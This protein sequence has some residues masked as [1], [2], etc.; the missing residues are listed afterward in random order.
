[1][2]KAKVSDR[3][4]STSWSYDLSG[5]GELRQLRRSKK[6]RNSIDCE[7]NVIM[8][9]GGLESR[10]A[11]EKFLLFLRGCCAYT[12]LDVALNLHPFLLAGITGGQVA[13]LFVPLIISPSIIIQR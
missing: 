9:G 7:D 12:L 8:A 13:E 3:D 1:M 6:R 10:G 11:T 4:L 2:Q 5:Q